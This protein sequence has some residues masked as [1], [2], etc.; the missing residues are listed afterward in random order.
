MEKTIVCIMAA[1]LAC[2]CGNLKGSSKIKDTQSKM[3]VSDD[4]PVKIRGYIYY[5]P[6]RKSGDKL[7]AKLKE[8]FIM[9]AEGIKVMEAPKGQKESWLFVL[10]KKTHA[11][12]GT[13]DD[14][15]KQAMEFFGIDYDLYGIIK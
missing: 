14:V 6:G 2:S 13:D 4:V 15:Y 7:A 5:I 11:P 12:R 1:L 9:N 10:G 8:D 3:A